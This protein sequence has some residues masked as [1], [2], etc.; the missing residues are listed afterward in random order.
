M[1]A[2]KG[3]TELRRGVGGGSMDMSFVQQILDTDQFV[4]FGPS[5]SIAT[6]MAPTRMSS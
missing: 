6:F 5:R 4:G 1:R 3:Y 2:V